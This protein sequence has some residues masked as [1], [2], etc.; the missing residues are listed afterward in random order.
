MA[1][2]HLKDVYRKAFYGAEDVDD[3][4]EVISYRTAVFGFL[5]CA[6]YLMVWHYRTGM[7]LKFIPLFLLGCL[8]MYLGITRVIAETGLI[9]PACAVDAT[10]L[11]ALPDG[12][13]RVDAEDDGVCGVVV[14][15]V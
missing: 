5:A 3:S 7:E 1:R 2:H 4:D 11:C 6:A 10:A 15:L 12:V 9:A 14:Y 13:G 8:V